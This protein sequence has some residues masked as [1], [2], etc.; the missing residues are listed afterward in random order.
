MTDD[1]RPRTEQPLVR[2]IFRLGTLK[3]LSF[4]DEEKGGGWSGK[5]ED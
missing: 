4:K 1:R 5:T 3:A 2:L